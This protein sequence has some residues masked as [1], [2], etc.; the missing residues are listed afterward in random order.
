[1]KELVLLVVLL[2]VSVGTTLEKE[3]NDRY[4]E[5][6]QIETEEYD[7]YNFTLPSDFHLGVSSAAY[8]YEGAWDEGGKG[9]SI[10]DRY[11]HTYPEAIADGTNGDVAADF[12]HKYKE[13]IKRVKDLGLDTFRFSI[14]WPRIMPTGL[15]DSVNQ[16][17]IDFYDDV[18][19]EV[20]KNGISPMVTMY[21]WDLPQYLQ[22][23]G[24]WTNEIIVDYFEDYADVLYSYYG[25]RVKL[26]LTLNEPTK[27]VDGYGGNVTGLGYAPNV[28][29][30]GIGT[31]LAGHTMLK[32]H[33]RAYHLYND[34]YRAFQKGRISLA[35]ETFW[36]EPQDSN[37]ES[38]HEAALQAIEFNLGWFA[39][40]IFSKEGDYPTVMKK[41]IAE[42]SYQEGYLKSRLPQFSTEEVKYIR[43]T[44]DFF[45]LNQYTTN[46][47]TF[48]ENGPSPS[49]T[50]D[51]GVTLVAPSD[52]P[53]SET[54]EWE[55]IVPKGL[56]KVL[57]YIKDRYGKKWEIVIT[58][59]G[60]ID[61]GEIMDSQRIVYIATYMIEMWK[62]MYID[63]VRVV[64]YMIWSLLDN[65]EWTSGYRSRSGLF[66][67]DFYHPDKIRTPKKS[68]EL[69]KT[70]AKTRRIPEKYVDHVKELDQLE[71]HN[72]S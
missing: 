36:Y 39:N 19:N 63:G 21:H 55:K 4:H 44:A 31:Y 23:L 54:S 57:N 14:A 37:S 71:F 25:D 46:R 40:P 61:D 17:G 10:W 7:F 69:V 6:Q 43:G 8:Q 20:I 13:D 47:A 38:D 52:W 3:F 29:A 53:A 5:D 65:M 45:G 32:A 1:M 51:T 72:Y 66:H 42:N 67:V 70:I 24:G 15:I 56:R 48:G 27:G 18:I 41:R 2:L 28:S 58:E 50:R 16:E 62:A 22:D 30:A 35:L 12:Y 64:G 33:A 68:T 26:W 59:N 49:Y 60:F 9:E 11:I 34:K